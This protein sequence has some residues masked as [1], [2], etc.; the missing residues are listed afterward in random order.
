MPNVSWVQLAN[1]GFPWQ[2]QSG[3][4]LTTAAT[5]TISP[6]GAGGTGADPA[7]LAFTPAMVIG[8]K[9][10]GIWT[11][12][13]TATNA[14]LAV[15]ASAY[16]TAAAG[17]TLLASTGAF[18]LPVSQAGLYWEADGEIQVRQHA[19]GIST[20]TL[21]THGKT[22]IQTAPYESTLTNSN[23]QILPMPA[24][25]GPTAAD[26]DTTLQH[27]IALAGTLSQAVG[28]PSLQCTQF[29]LFPYS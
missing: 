11:C 10:R 20:P 21:Y 22:K 3:T 23:M 13:S 28:S 18:A 25:S 7:I 4:A 2:T 16:G 9:A 24:T 29:F 1:W 27:T 19:Q 14:T 12:G 8:W 26:V 6:E 5:A 17:G 15:Y